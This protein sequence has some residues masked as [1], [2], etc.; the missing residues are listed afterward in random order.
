MP[1]VFLEALLCASEV[2]TGVALRS[3]REAAARAAHQRH[4]AAR[5]GISARAPPG[6]RAEEGVER[7]RVRGRAGAVASCHADRRAGRKARRVAC[8]WTAMRHR[9]AALSVLQAADD[10]A[11]QR[12]IPADS[13]V[14]EVPT[15]VQWGREAESTPCFAARTPSSV[16]NKAAFPC[17]KVQQGCTAGLA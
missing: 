7:S 14:R 11:V 13:P 1:R 10:A 8:L 16:V 3:S 2:N 9:A 12:W 5:A 17:T 4:L 6:G 15:G